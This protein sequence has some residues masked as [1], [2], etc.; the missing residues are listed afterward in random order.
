MIWQLIDALDPEWD[1]KGAPRP[2]SNAMAFVIS[3]SDWPEVSVS[4]YPDPVPVF[5]ISTTTL[6]WEIPV[7]GSQVVDTYVMSTRINYDDNHP[8]LDGDDVRPIN[9]VPWPERLPKAVFRGGP[10][11]NTQLHSNQWELCPRNVA[12]RAGK[13]RPDLLDIGLSDFPPEAANESVAGHMSLPDHSK[14]KY[15]LTFDGHTYGR[16]TTELMMTQSAILMQQ[17]LFDYR[18][19]HYPALVPWHHFVPIYC[20]AGYCPLAS[21]V[22]ALRANDEL[23]KTIGLAANQF[24]RTYLSHEGRACYW[25]LL[26]R[27]MENFFDFEGMKENEETA[28]AVD[29][30]NTTAT[31]AKKEVKQSSFEADTRHLF[32][33][34]KENKNA[35][36][37]TDVLVVDPRV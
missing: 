26:L 37:G 10:T 2:P 25:R 16:R 29:K 8:D 22:D 18:E 3:T 30:N 14:Y 1:A 4:K 34:R 33:V 28:M 17:S 32:E 11:C 35:L 7:P 31:L 19:F 6:A 12:Y 21:T 13:E 9:L 5:G 15:V 27:S 20:T 24:L 23:A 36:S